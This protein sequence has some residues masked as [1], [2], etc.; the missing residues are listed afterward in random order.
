MINIRVFLYQLRSIIITAKSEKKNCRRLFSIC[1]KT[2]K[3]SKK[4][5]FNKTCFQESGKQESNKIIKLLILRLR[6][7]RPLSLVCIMH[8]GLPE[9]LFAGKKDGTFFSEW[10]DSFY[11]RDIQELF[12]IRNRT[13]FIK[14]LHFLLRQ[15]NGL[16]DYSNLAKYADL[17][18]PTVKVHIEAMSSA[19]AVYLLPP[20]Y[21]GSRHEIIR[22]PKCDTFDTNH[23][24]VRNTA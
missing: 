3:N 17:N 18:R 9:P 19:H 20:F 12:G 2:V 21:G 13:G 8:G 24:D 7:G 4:R 1:P 16:I 22:R 5:H 11:A 10:I 14:L 6:M 23:R 15:S